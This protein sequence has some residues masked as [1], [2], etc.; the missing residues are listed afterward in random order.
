MSSEESE[1]KI[2]GIAFRED[3]LLKD[4]LEE[5]F[6]AGKA[7]GKKEGWDRGFKV[8]FDDGYEQHKSSKAEEAEEANK[9]TVWDGEDYKVIVQGEG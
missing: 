4:F 3:T 5:I 9:R 6:Q 7:E 8:G 1:F 2:G